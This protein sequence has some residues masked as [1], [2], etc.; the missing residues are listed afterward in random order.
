MTPSYQAAM[1]WRSEGAFHP[2]QY[3]RGSAEQIEYIEAAE[4]IEQREAQSH[5]VREGS[6]SQVET[7]H[8]SGRAIGQR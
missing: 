5:E 1:D 7:P 6:P 3:P 2:E 4:A 8:V